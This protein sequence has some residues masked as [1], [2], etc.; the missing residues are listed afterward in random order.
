MTDVNQSETRIEQQI[1]KHVN[2]VGQTVAGEFNEATEEEA[3]KYHVKV[4]QSVDHLESLCTPLIDEDYQEK[5]NKMFGDSDNKRKSHNENNR[6]SLLSD[7]KTKF[8]LLIDLLH[9]KGVL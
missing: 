5:K 6:L 8:R 3:M 2:R 9:R 1:R 7:A 4:H